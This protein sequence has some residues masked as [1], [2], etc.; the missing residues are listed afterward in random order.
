MRLRRRPSLFLESEVS[1]RMNYK[2]KV[3]ESY[4][5]GGEVNRASQTGEYGMEFIYTKKALDPWISDDKKVIELGCG[6]GYYGMHYG[7][8]CLE[9]VG[10][11]LSPVNVEIFSKQ[12]A[13]AGY[14]NVR[15]E[16]GDA[17]ALTNIPDESQDVVLCLGPMYHLNR[18]DRKI[19]MQECKRICR[20]DGVIIFSFINKTGAMAKFGSAGGWDGIL[21]PNIEECVMNRGTDDVHT[22]IFYYTMP[23]EM[24]ED[25]A[26]AGLAKVRMAGVDFLLLEERI[27]NFTEEQRR[28]WFHF[29]ELVTESEYAAALCNHALLICQKEV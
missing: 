17:T 18:D 9:Y 11:D 13:E 6:G 3:I 22:D 23:E 15:A 29:A 14:E 2:Q 25:A 5:G 24:L 8:R 16:V 28:I 19:C 7:T 4:A 10:V 27:E 21:T 12:I 26:E 20:P 1:E